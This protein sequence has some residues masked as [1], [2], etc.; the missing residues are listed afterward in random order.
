MF[1]PTVSVC[2]SK[3]N[4]ELSGEWK[5]NSYLLEGT[6][7]GLFG[8]RKIKQNSSSNIAL[9]NIR[10]LNISNAKRLS[11][12]SFYTRV[13]PTVIIFYLIDSKTA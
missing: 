4:G 3:E 12:S 7:Y 6:F 9:G 2:L 8:K 1:E 11:V 10:T 13:E 5:K